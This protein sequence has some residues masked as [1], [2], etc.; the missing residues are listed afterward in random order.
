[1]LSALLPSP[2]FVL[3]VGVICSPVRALA[4]GSQTVPL[5]LSISYFTAAALS[6]FLFD[7]LGKASEWIK[8]QQGSRVSKSF[9]QTYLEL[10]HGILNLDTLI[11]YFVFICHRLVALESQETHWCKRR[12]NMLSFYTGT[13]TW[14]TDNNSVTGWPGLSSLASSALKLNNNV[15]LSMSGKPNQQTFQKNVFKLI[16]TR[17]PF[18]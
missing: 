3:I 13:L 7:I 1:M 5:V 17:E 6:F 14:A 18:F 12:S 16:F 4:A 11:T 8:R 2:R 9:T 15:S 10:P